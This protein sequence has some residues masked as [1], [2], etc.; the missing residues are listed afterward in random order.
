M[1]VYRLPEDDRVPPEHV[2]VT[3]NCKVMYI[4][5]AYIGFLNE[6]FITMHG[7]NNAKLGTR[8]TLVTEAALVTVVT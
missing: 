4:G 6:R 3:R 8:V 5:C 1:L 7:I 2:G